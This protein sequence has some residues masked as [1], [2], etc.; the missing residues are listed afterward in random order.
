MEKKYNAFISY[1]HSEK[2][3]M[4][5][6]EIQTRLERF[7]IPKEIQK[8]TGVKRFER[9]FR[10][11]EELPITSDLN[12]NI[13]KALEE[14]DHLIVICSERTSESI[15][16]RKEIETFLK[17]HK[18]KNIFTV[19]VDGEPGEVIPDILL[20]DTVTRKLADGREETREE[21]IEPLSCDYRIG[22]KKARK[23][24]LPRL[25]AS[26]LGCS[27]DELIQRRRQYIRRR[28][29]MI[30]SLASIV[31]A[32]IIA[33]LC[34]S[35]V[36]I[37]ANYDLAQKNYQLA[38]QNYDTAQ[39]N[40]MESL[41]NQSRYLAAESGVLLN[42]DDRVGAIQLAIAALPSEEN[43]RPLTSEAT[44]ALHNALGTYYVPGYTDISPVWKYSSGKRIQKFLVS[45]DQKHLA[46]LDESGAVTVWDLTDH[47]LTKDFDPAV[48]NG[49]DIAFTSD[50]GL[51]ISGDNEIVK[52]SADL[53]DYEWLVDIEGEY[54]YGDILKYFE[55]S[56]E[57]V[58]SGYEEL[59]ILDSAS[60][61]VTENHVIE[62]E[63][64]PEEESEVGSLLRAELDP[65]GRY[66]EIECL[67]YTNYI[68][69]IYD[70]EEDNWVKAD[71]NFGYISNRC[72]SGDG[73][74]ISY[75]DDAYAGSSSYGDLQSLSESMLVIAKFSSTD[76]SL[77]WKCEIPHTLVGFESKL[78]ECSFGPDGD[79][80]T[81][82]FAAFS[83]KCAF[84][85]TETG[86]VLTV[87]ELPSEFIDSYFS[88]SGDRIFCVLRDGQ[89]L[90]IYLTDP[91]ASMASRPY[92]NEKVEDTAIFGGEGYGT[93]YLVEYSSDNSLIEYRSGFYDRSFAF[94]EG[95]DTGVSIYRATCVGG[96]ALLFGDN[97]KL[98]CYDTSGDRIVWGTDID[99]SYYT[100][101]SFLG[102]DNEYLYIQNDN[103]DP[104]SDRYG[105]RFLRVSIRDGASEYIDDLPGFSSMGTY[106]VGS[107]VWFPTWGESGLGDGISRLDMKSGDITF[108]EITGDVPDLVYSARPFVSPDEKK[109]ILIHKHN[110]M[111]AAFLVDAKE[112]SSTMLDSLCNEFA[113]WKSDS[114]AFALCDTSGFEVFDDKGKELFS[115]QSGENKLVSV[116]LSDE[117]VISVDS[118]GYVSFY[119][120]N[121]N[122]TANCEIM[123]M[124]SSTH[125]DTSFEFYDDE[126]I[127]NSGS[128]GNVIDLNE[129]KPLCLVSGYL[130]YAV[131]SNR[132]IVKT[133]SPSDKSVSAGFFVRR[134]IDLL[135]E[136]GKEYLKEANITEEM[137]NRY[138]I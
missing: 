41:S 53:S 122:L 106:C 46:L 73:V 77:L 127:I 126:L 7:K 54:D 56:D 4:I 120:Y 97:M 132:F 43:N 55:E 31:L 36:Q 27:Y 91:D 2:D 100:A 64:V 49:K 105:S 92:F 119:D 65:T 74:V 30:V 90:S 68:A 125:E 69:Y 81:C 113:V 115:A 48:L 123:V 51:V 78:L 79:T 39:V 25:A 24:E 3:S 70:R 28:N 87:R 108:T 135:I 50:S 45:P 103:T 9:I 124:R 75:V 44:Y 121:G 96:K 129:L 5:A 83:N 112:G 29:M 15:W 111:P 32:G 11:K 20:H 16:V 85:D 110:D 22:I 138:G 33:Y 137:K 80:T 131:E 66:M 67:D 136:E 94:L 93:S 128:I 102:T 52:F 17:Y 38:Q 84:I 89:Y 133:Y 6:S 37:R 35:L 57:I 71:E 86:E 59:K 61:K 8:R 88:T 134:D 76:G 58:Y 107:A 26:M 18:K 10:D 104:D 23:I 34:W 60:G 62:E 14:S 13:E 21:L 72:F 116:C 19:L 114:S 63:I 130:G 99:G 109:V 98:Y 1:R 118:F 47:S 12:E 42:N 101:V 117:Y 95:M 82:V 40:L